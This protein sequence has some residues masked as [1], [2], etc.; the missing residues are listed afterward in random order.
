MNTNINQ[1][2]KSSFQRYMG[3]FEGYSCKF[4]PFIPNLVACGFSQY[5]G[6]IGNGRLSIFNQN[7]Q[8]GLLEENR[9]FNTNDG[10]FDIAWSEVNENH[11]VTG[12]G[13]GSLKL[14]DMKLNQP[15]VNMREHTGEVFGVSWNHT[16]TNIVAS[17]GMDS[18]VRLYDIT[19]GVGIGCLVDHKKVVYSVTWHPTLDNVVASASADQ[20]VKLWDIRSGKVMKSLVSQNAE[21]MHMD[22]NKYENT[23]AT[24]GADGTILIFD[25]RGTGDIPVSVLNGH[26]L[27]CRKVMF[28][29]FFSGIMASVGYDMNVIIWDIKKNAPV[30]IFKHH[31]EFVYGLDFSL[32]DNKKL[33]TTAWDRSL[34]VFNWDEQFKI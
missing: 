20:T 18:T 32:F 23:I 2:N 31:R 29:P 13:D 19:K 27:T 22:F 17:A 5:Y 10:I 28:S 16:A 9:R 33:A 11:I 3:E 30:N 1:I 6:I 15:I 24:A 7:Q 8:T 25:L 34:Y 12:C 4:S 14:W 21:M 26:T